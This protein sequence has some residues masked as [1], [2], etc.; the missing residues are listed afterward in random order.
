[1]ACH[2][3]FAE[4]RAQRTHAVVPG[5]PENRSCRRSQAQ[6]S[7][8]EHVGSDEGVQAVVQGALSY[9]E[10]TEVQDCPAED[11]QAGHAIGKGRWEHLE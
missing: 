1:M 2:K 5:Q 9:T 3:R 7:R 6:D 10:T 11:G 8:R 4:Q